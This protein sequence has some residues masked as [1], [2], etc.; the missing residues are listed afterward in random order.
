MTKRYLSC[1]KRFE[2]DGGGNV[3]E[4]KMSGTTIPKSKKKESDTK[5]KRLFSEEL[6]LFVKKNKLMASTYA[7]S[8][9]LFFFTK[10][11]STSI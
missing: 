10:S 4:T 9:I 1:Q 2:N 11:S 6:E 5:C 7:F 8:T 3:E